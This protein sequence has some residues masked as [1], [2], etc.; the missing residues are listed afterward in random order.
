MEGPPRGRLCVRA[1]GGR[2]RLGRLRAP[3]VADAD[4]DV[5]E[6]GVS[7]DVWEGRR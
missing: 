4:A 7:E 5:G 2:E 3:P 1:E 6:G